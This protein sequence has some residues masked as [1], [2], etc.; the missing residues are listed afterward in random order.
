MLKQHTATTTTFVQQIIDFVA[1]S[2]A[3]S[4]T[5]SFET[6]KKSSYI[7]FYPYYEWNPPTYF[8]KQ[9]VCFKKYPAVTVSLI[10]ILIGRKS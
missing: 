10:K 5:N 6:L 3:Y 1:V 9:I 8:E 7:E 4:T 2:K